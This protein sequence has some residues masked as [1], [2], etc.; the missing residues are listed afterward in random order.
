TTSRTA[1]ITLAAGAGG[2]TPCSA[3]ASRWARSAMLRPS[4]RSGASATSRANPLS[5]ISGAGASEAGP[6]LAAPRFPATP[7]APSRRPPGPRKDARLAHRS[8]L[9]LPPPAVALPLGDHPLQDHTLLRPHQARQRDEM[10]GDLGVALVRHRDAADDVRPPCLRQLA[11][12]RPGE[13]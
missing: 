12:L 7:P 3:S 2:T 4:C 13:L 1:P 5:T 8:P 11:D 10:L 9:R 6:T